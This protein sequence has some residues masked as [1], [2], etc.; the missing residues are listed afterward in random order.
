MEEESVDEESRTSRE[1][2][3][4]WMK[5]RAGELYLEALREAGTE[6]GRDLE[7]HAN[8]LYRA[9]NTLHVLELG[10]DGE[11]EELTESDVDVVVPEDL[12]A[13]GDEEPPA[14]EAG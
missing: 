4:E 3:L 5:E 1:E 7:R 6:K 10:E 2:V 12:E 13:R 8:T 11:L 14:S 9:I